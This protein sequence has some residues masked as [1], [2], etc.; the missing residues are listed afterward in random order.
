MRWAPFWAK[1]ILAK[2]RGIC[3]EA[4]HLFDLAEHFWSPHQGKPVPA[5]EAGEI[6]HRHRKLGTHDIVS[7]VLAQWRYGVIYDPVIK[8]VTGDAHAA[9]AEETGNLPGVTVA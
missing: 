3:A 2:S 7:V 4:S 5:G 8:C 1:L 6:F 9:M